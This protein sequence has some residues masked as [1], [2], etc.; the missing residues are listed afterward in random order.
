M[1]A[2]ANTVRQNIQTQQFPAP[3]S[4]DT[5]GGH[6]NHVDHPAPFPAPL[7]NGVHPEVSIGALLQRSV[8]EVVNELIER[9]GH[10]GDLTFRD[11]LDAHGRRQPVNPAGADPV[12]VTFADHLHQRPLGSSAGREQPFGEI[13]ALMA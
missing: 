11:S 4:V 1:K 13:A 10:L 2:L 9:F 3:V 6:G 7:G 8:A 12:D 5:G